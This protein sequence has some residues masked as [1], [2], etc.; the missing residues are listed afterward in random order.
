MRTPWLVTPPQTP[1]LTLEQAKAHLRIDHDDDDAAVANAIEGA[2]SLVDGYHGTL[3]RALITQT[4]AIDASWWPCHWGE[5][6]IGLRLMP[7][8]VQSLEAVVTVDPN[9]VET[10]DDLGLYRFVAPSDTLSLR[11]GATQPS[12]ATRDYRRVVRF[13]T[14]YG[15]G[16]EDIPG[17][18][19]SALLLMVGDLYEHRETVAVGVSATSLPTAAT[20]D[21]LLA[22]FRRFNG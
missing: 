17:A 22:P 1:P 5:Y 14:G 21:R 18:I 2:V 4:W 7:G 12:L 9:G 3:G 6:S 11:S 20:V 10:D 15:D 19:R 16:P 8:P 13:V